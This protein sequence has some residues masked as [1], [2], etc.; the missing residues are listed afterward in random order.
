MSN[1]ILK[2]KK[3]TKKILIISG[4]MG[5]ASAAIIGSQ[6]TSITT[7]FLRTATSTSSVVSQIQIGERYG[8]VF[9]DKNGRRFEVETTKIGYESMLVKNYPTYPNAKFIGAFGGKPI[10]ATSTPK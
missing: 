1:L 7:Q 2:V 6:P 5:V 8:F 10:Y 9:Q 3:H 4:L